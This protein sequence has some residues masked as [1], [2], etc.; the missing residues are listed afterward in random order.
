LAEILIKLKSVSSLLDF[1]RRGR[2]TK[3]H[4]GGLEVILSFDGFDRESGSWYFHPPLVQ[5]LPLLHAGSDIRFSIP[6]SY[7]GYGFRIHGASPTNRS[8]AFG[9]D[10]VFQ[11][12]AEGN[13]IA[14]S[15]SRKVPVRK[16]KS[17][18][19]GLVEDWTYTLLRL[20]EELEMEGAD[21]SAP[22]EMLADLDLAPMDGEFWTRV[23]SI[24]QESWSGLSMSEIVN[25]DH[26]DANVA[27]KHDRVKTTLDMRKP[28]GG[29]FGKAKFDFSMDLRIGETDTIRLV[30]TNPP[31]YNGWHTAFGYDLDPPAFDF[32]R[33]GLNSV[34]RSNKS[35]LSALFS[36]TI[37]DNAV[38]GVEAS[39]ARD[40]ASVESVW[41]DVRALAGPVRSRRLPPRLKLY[42][43]GFTGRV[44]KKVQAFPTHIVWT[45]ATCYRP[46]ISG[47]VE[48]QTT[49]SLPTGRRRSGR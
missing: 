14:Q 47:C 35:A 17:L 34:S 15:T 18:V 37:I 22:A 42:R 1:L 30:D 19:I 11:I 4:Q 44:R 5:T 2:G 28:G 31:A 46:R 16:I 48:V 36:E 45:N 20:Q 25:S 26:A 41:Q 40:M 33:P 7:Y 23:F 24:D 9:L 38:N 32:T 12:S 10:T 39:I 27:I 43:A 13:W 49:T 21:S 8:L 3:K 29:R 6:Q